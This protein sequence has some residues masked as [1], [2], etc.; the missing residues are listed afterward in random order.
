M[1]CNRGGSFNDESFSSARASALRAFRQI[2]GPHTSEFQEFAEH[3]KFD[4]GIDGDVSYST[5]HERFLET[6]IQAI[7]PQDKVAW[8]LPFKFMLLRL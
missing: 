1:N 2:F 8:L 3:L 4:L 6:G 5:L 7:R